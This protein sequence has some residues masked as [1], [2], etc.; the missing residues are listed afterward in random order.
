MFDIFKKRSEVVLDCFT[1]SLTTYEYFKIQESKHFIPKWWEKLPNNP[2]RESNYV[3]E[4]PT[5]NMKGCVAFTNYFNKGYVIPLWSDL[6]IKAEYESINFEFA[7]TVY[8]DVIT[9]SPE[10]SNFAFCDNFHHLKLT[11]PWAFKCNKDVNFYWA[12]A[13][14]SFADNKD[15]IE[16]FWI[17]PGILNF[18]NMNAGHVNIFLKRIVNKY[19]LKAGYPLVHLVP[20]TDKK[21]TLKYHLLEENGMPSIF[22]YLHSSPIFTFKQKKFDAIKRKEEKIKPK[23]PFNFKKY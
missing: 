16:N 4:I 8:G 1:T 10:Q 11:S 9:H 2:T 23:C 18:K 22:Q 21:V 7:N 17:M 13:F 20:L 6:V 19:F 14:W 12:P 15:F 3:G 5:A